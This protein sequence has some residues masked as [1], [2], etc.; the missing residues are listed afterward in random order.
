V[1]YF[2]AEQEFSEMATN[3]PPVPSNIHYDAKLW[4]FVKSHAQDGDLW[5]NVAR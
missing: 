1:Q 3:R 2:S 4:S 5:W